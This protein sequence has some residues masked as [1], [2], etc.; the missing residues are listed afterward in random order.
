MAYKT[1]PFDRSGNPAL[2]GASWFTQR[3]FSALR[4]QRIIVN[5]YEAFG[6]HYWLRSSLRRDMNPSWSLNQVATICC[7][8][9]SW[10]GSEPPQCFAVSRIIYLQSSEQSRTILQRFGEIFTPKSASS[11]V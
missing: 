8:M 11:R 9:R 1:T 7:E 5:S 2:F 6:S 4:E 10:Q 3:T